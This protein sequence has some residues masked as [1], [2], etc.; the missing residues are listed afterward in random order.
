MKKIISTLIALVMLSTTVIASA[1]EY[2]DV[3]KRSAGEAADESGLTFE[4]Y[5]KYSYLNPDT[6]EWMSENEA[7][8]TSLAMN[9]INQSGLSVDEFK[10]E[11]GLTIDITDT[12]T[13]GELYDSMPLSIYYAD[14]FDEAKETYGLGDDV[15]GDTLYGEVRAIIEKADM[16]NTERVVFSDI[17]YKHWAYYY[18]TNM[19]K[20]GIIDGYDDGTYLPEKNV[21]RA[22]FAKILSITAG[23]E[24]S[25]E[26]PTYSDVSDDMWYSNYVYSVGEYIASFD[27]NFN[28][29]A[30]ATREMVATAIAK[31]LGVSDGVSPDF[32]TSKFT[33]A[34]TISA[35]NAVYVADAVNK[36]IIDGFDDNT[37]CGNSTLT[38][39]QAATIMYRAFFEYVNIS[40]AFDIVVMKSGDREV[41]LGDV[42]VNS[43]LPEDIDYTD[44]KAL[45]DAIAE[46][47]KTIAK[48]YNLEYKAQELK[49]SYDDVADYAVNSR[50]MAAYFYGYRAFCTT[51][52]SLGTSI[53]AFDEMCLMYAYEDMLLERYN[54]K[55]TDDVELNSAIEI[56]E[57]AWADIT[58]EDIAMG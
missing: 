6:P 14:N 25:N 33:D 40:P 19:L 12:T 35:E 56:F 2:L 51:L 27:G 20:F 7:Q 17:G 18:I 58:I 41:T 48:L 44:E 28:P 38:R 29:D 9:I 1:S 39:A 32:L 22:E 3:T 8:M 4:E 26:H 50:M 57:D 24:V 45:H 55:Q 21:T 54:Y 49:I 52:K 47:V 5:K 30:P 36:G 10:K 13:V 23:L 31:L 16:D 37:I 46:A 53:E 42:L 43:P 11:Y 34:D 15:T